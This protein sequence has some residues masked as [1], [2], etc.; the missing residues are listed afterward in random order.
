MVFALLLGLGDPEAAPGEWNL[1]N[2]HTAEAVPE[3][4]KVCMSVLEQ[5]F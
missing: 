1:F 4:R 2:L 3:F 5:V